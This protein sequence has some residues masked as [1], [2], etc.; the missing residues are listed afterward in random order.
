MNAEPVDT[1]LDK[2][3]QHEADYAY[4]QLLAARTP[5]TAQGAIQLLREGSTLNTAGALTCIDQQAQGVWLVVLPK[6]S[7]MHVLVYC[8]P[9]LPDFETVEIAPE[10]C[11]C[12]HCIELVQKQQDQAQQTMLEYIVRLDVEPYSMLIL[13]LSFEEAHEI[14]YERWNKMHVLQIVRYTE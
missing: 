14:A 7:Y 8:T 4:A 3:D 5:D 6:E 1:Y 11:P 9:H 13:A 2:Q 10:N 12:A